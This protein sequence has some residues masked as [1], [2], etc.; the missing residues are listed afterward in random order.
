MLVSLLSN[1]IRSRVRVSLPSIVFKQ[2]FSAEN[3]DEE[4]ELSEAEVAER[5]IEQ[6]KKL[7]LRNRLSSFLT[8]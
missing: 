3:E 2:S 6:I 4:A 5:A 1:S 8:R 7:K